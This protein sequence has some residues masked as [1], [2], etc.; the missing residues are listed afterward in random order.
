MNFEGEFV[1]EGGGPFPPPIGI[2]LSST[3]LTISPD[4]PYIGGDATI[5]FPTGV[6]VRSN[7]L[8][9][10]GTGAL[11]LGNTNGNGNTSIGHNSLINLANVA[12]T[13][14]TALGQ[15]AGENLVNG[16]NNT[17][18]GYKAGGDVHGPPIAF[19]RS[20]FIGDRATCLGGSGATD[21]VALGYN[22]IVGGNTSIVI[23]SGANTNSTNSIA[24]GTNA[25]VIRDHSICL[26]TD[27]VFVALGDSFPLSAFSF[28]GDYRQTVTGG[29]SGN[30]QDLI[31]GQVVSTFTC[32]ADATP[33]ILYSFPINL[34]NSPTTQVTNFYKMDIILST[35]VGGTVQTSAYSSTNACVGYL[36]GPTSY[37][38]IGGTLPFTMSP[39]ALLNSANF[40][41]S[42][43]NLNLVLS[44][45]LN[46]QI[47]NMTINY[48]TFG[49]QI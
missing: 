33:T 25:T 28:K 8:L 40:S 36:V 22:A 15:E 5:D 35:S 7:Q 42:G 12:N 27:G 6:A 4:N 24:I 37:Q 11:Q 21:S 47:V 1:G 34:G 39:T 32:P 30:I 43:G 14:N 17:L 10:I 16:S 31:K 49:A 19:S 3:T 18:I 48:E 2:S 20:T 38:L 29:S 44:W 23:G 26:G 13:E 9:G 41:I 46:N 45:R